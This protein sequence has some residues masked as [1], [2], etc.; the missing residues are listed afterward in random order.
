[1]RFV[2]TFPV[3]GPLADSYTE[4]DALDEHTARLAVIG[5]YGTRGWAGIHDSDLKATTAMIVRYDLTCVVLG[6]S[7]ETAQE[8]VS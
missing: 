7:W 6:T 2:V 3:G 5:V 8:Y 1:M 4:I